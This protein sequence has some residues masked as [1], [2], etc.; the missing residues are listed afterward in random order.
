MAVGVRACLPRYGRVRWVSYRG[1]VSLSCHCRV[2]GDLPMP[3]PGHTGV[4]AFGR[5]RPAQRR[6]AAR[7][8]ITSV[9][10]GSPAAARGNGTDPGPKTPRTP[11][12]SSPPRTPATPA[13]AP[14]RLH[15]RG[16]RTATHS[17]GRPPP[18]TPSGFRRAWQLRD[19]VKLARSRL[20]RRAVGYQKRYERNPSDPGGV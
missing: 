13:P 6:G 16:R 1:V 15:C 2:V 9:G 8:A 7:R 17:A 18:E 20:G 3:P 12:T 5:Q 19:D 4:T 10:T 14:V 11:R